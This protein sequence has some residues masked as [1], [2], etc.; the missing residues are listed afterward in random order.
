MEL[1]V[2]KVSVVEIKARFS[3]ILA[4]VESGRDVVITRRGIPVARMSAID[5][6]KKA[7]DLGSIDAFRKA[8]PIGRQRSAALI[9]K[10]RDERY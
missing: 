2:N 9:R 8:L 7:L 10:M 5:G 1:S 4:A 6:V 3:E